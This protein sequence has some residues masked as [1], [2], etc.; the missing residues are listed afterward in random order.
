MVQKSILHNIEF[1]N[2]NFCAI[3]FVPSEICDWFYTNL[4]ILK[5]LKQNG[6]FGLM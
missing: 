5:L 1:D 2:L 3:I 6:F 4:V